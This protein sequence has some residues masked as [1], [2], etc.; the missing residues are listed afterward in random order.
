MQQSF[1]IL[2]MHIKMGT[3]TWDMVWDYLYGMSMLQL[4]FFFWFLPIPVFNRYEKRLTRVKKECLT[5]KYCINC[6]C[7]TKGMMMTKEGCKIKCYDE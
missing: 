1:A 5:G 6:G 7:H 2:K 4:Y 3:F